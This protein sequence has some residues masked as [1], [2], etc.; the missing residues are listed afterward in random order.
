MSMT[1]QPHAR[2][3]SRKPM[4]SYRPV[5]VAVVAFCIAGLVAVG[6]WG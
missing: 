4:K 6:V 3:L 1:N 2:R 5:H